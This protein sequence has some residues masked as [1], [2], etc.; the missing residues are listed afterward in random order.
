MDRSPTLPVT[1]LALLVCLADAAPT[2]GR[3]VHVLRSVA[4]NIAALGDI[5]PGE[6]GHAL[7]II[8]HLARLTAALPHHGDERPHQATRRA[9]RAL[10]QFAGPV[11]EPQV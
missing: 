1:W 5:L 11:T 4:T 2:P 6:T 9:C 7:L 3:Q 8:A 10:E